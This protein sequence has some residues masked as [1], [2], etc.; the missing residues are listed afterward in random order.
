MIQS[1]PWI[2]T[3]SYLER[4]ERRKRVRDQGMGGKEPTVWPLRWVYV[5]THPARRRPARIGADKDGRTNQG[6]RRA[7]LPLLSTESGGKGNLRGRSGLGDRWI[8]RWQGDRE[9]RGIINP[10]VTP[11]GMGFPRARSPQTPFLYAHGRGSRGRA[12]SWCPSW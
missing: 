1:Q 2:L 7:R 10:K 3:E 5:K 9:T 11:G 8:P 6:S 4:K 12:P